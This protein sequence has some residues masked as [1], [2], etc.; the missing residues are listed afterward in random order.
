VDPGTRWAY[1]N[2][3]YLLLQNVIENAS[4]VSY[5]TYTTS[6]LKSKT[7]MIGFWFDGVYYSR[8]RDMARF[9]LM[10][11]NNGIWDSD[12]VL[13][14][15]TYFQQMIQP[16][17]SINESYGYLWWLNG[18]NSYMLPQLQLVFSGELIPNAPSDLFCGLGKN[19]QKLYIIPSQN[20]VIIRM[21]DPSGTPAFALTNY[22]N[23]LWARVNQFVCTAVS[24]NE[25]NTPTKLKLFPNPASKY[26]TITNSASNNF[27]IFDSYGK[28]INVFRDNNNRIDISN[29]SRG[30]Y[31]ISDGLKSEKLIVE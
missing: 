19:D 18:Y 30:M 26:I 3:L 15:Q 31:F 7:G 29:L 20:M 9:G 6:K 4:G 11:L 13:H 22:D 28:S 25:I 14:D 27:L 21:G 23:E 12:T 1:H 17:Q 2:A 5:N 16:S 10:I 8:P 24:T